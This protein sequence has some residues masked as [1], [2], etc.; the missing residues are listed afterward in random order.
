M[1]IRTKRRK[2]LLYPED[3]WKT[4]WDTIISLNLLMMCITMPIFI[5]FVDET[6]TDQR[7][8]ID[9]VTLNLVQDIIFGIDIFVVFHSVFYN[10]D[11]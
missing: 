11:F 2:C 6:K 9:W 8:S 3:P 1:S 5:A 10:E 4:R 7:N